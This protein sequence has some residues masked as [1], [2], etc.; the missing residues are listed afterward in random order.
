[1]GW[2]AQGGGLRAEGSGQ[3]VHGG[4]FMVEGS[5]WRVHGWRRTSV[6]C[7][8]PHAHTHTH[9]HKTCMHS[10]VYSHAISHV[11]MSALA[12]LAAQDS[13]FGVSV[14]GSD[15]SHLVVVWH[16]RWVI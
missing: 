11:I 7:V 14:K 9:A 10:F 16:Q 3:R 4:G 5:W 6:V 12:A 13:E 2:R 15:C 1:M 8:H